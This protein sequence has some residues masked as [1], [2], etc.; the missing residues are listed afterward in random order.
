MWPKPFKITYS[1][2]PEIRSIKPISF[3]VI[4]NDLNL[5]SR[6][7]SFTKLHRVV[8]YCI[9]FMKNCKAKNGSKQI[10]YLSTTE[11]NESLFVLTRLVQSEAFRDEIHCLT[12]SKP[13]SK[14]SKLYTLSPFLDDKN[15]IRLGGRIHNSH[16]NF[17]KKFPILL[18]A[19]HDLTY[20]II[21]H[22]HKNLLHAGP[23][24]VLAHLRNKFWVLNGKNSV[25]KI[26]RQCITCFKVNPTEV[27]QPMG[28]LPEYRLKPT[29][30]FLI[31]GVDFAG[32]F[33]IKDGK[34]RNRKFIKAYL[35]LFVCF[36]TK[37][38]HLEIAGDLTTDCFLNVLKRFVSRRGLCQHMHSD[39]GLN[40][41]GA[42]NELKRIFK[43]IFNFNNDNPIMTYLNKNSITWHFIPPRSPHFGGLWEANI[44]GAKHHMKRI[45]GNSFLTYEEL[46]TVVVQIEAVLNSRPL[47]PL[48]SDPAD[49]IALTPSHFLIGD[50]LTTIPQENV[51]DTPVNRLSLY[52]KLQQMLQHFWRRWSTEYISN[53][54]NRTRWNSQSPQEIQPNTM[55]LLK[56]DNLPP[57]QWKLGRVSEVYRGKDNIVRVVSVK[58]SSGIVKRAVRKLCILPIDNLV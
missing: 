2:I 28:N 13:I 51:V 21:K 33:L 52:K 56:E 48:S 22:T 29:R 35:C 42:D 8:T 31:S 14:K 19:K 32:P 30:P 50:V 20:L 45:L 18:P 38:V 24:T 40:F 3:P 6:Y 25:K 1:E 55:V 44:K 47:T 43:S 49:L 26:L 39:N 46:Y 57:L 4:I 41:V 23:Q 15:I 54:Q 5:F 27:T 37:A 12:N 58:T 17:D 36:A 11:L 53:L 7:S 16:F 34:L 9:R 10:G